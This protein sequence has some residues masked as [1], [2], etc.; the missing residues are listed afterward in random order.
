LFL[1]V[2]MDWQNKNLAF[3]R[4]YLDD[5]LYWEPLAAS[6][7]DEAYLRYYN[8]AGMYLA[9]IAKIAGTTILEPCKTEKEGKQNPK[10]AELKPYDCDIELHAKFLVGKF[11]LDCGK[12]SIQA[13]ELLIGK[14]ERNFTTR[15]TTLSLGVGVYG[16]FGGSFAG[17]GAGAEAGLSMSAFLNIDKTGALTDGGIVN[18]AGAS[19]GVK[20][21]A[22]E[23]LGF[24]K[25]F[26]EQQVGFE[27]RL[28]IN[29][30][31]TFDEGPLKNIIPPQEK[32]LNKNVKVYP[33]K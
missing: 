8:W 11:S 21:E 14:I 16:G 26:A 3:Q 31:W 12:F 23:R 24:T 17:I 32:P 9:A 22:G 15:Q 7:T 2:D 1:T 20:F 29:S 19:A 33:Q 10:E 4:K 6:S 30:G 27:S 18:S 28:G 13:G 25:K 5:L